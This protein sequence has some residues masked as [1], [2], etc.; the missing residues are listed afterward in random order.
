[1]TTES[2][3]RPNLKPTERS[4]PGAQETEARMQGDR[5]S[6]RAVADHRDH[7]P[8]AE[9]LAT[10]DQLGEDRPADAFAMLPS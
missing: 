1:M 4:V 2:T 10:L 3:Q 6:L 5:S 7:L 8:V 9:P